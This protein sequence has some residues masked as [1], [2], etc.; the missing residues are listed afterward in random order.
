ML[1]KVLSNAKCFLLQSVSKVCQN[2]IMKTEKPSVKSITIPWDKLGRAD[3][4]TAELLLQLA[5]GLKPSQVVQAY[6]RDLPEDEKPITESYLRVIKSR[7]RE[8]F[9]LMHGDLLEHV[10]LQMVTGALY[11]AIDKAQQSILEYQ[12]VGKQGSV[13]ELINGAQMLDKLRDKLRAELD[14][15]QSNTAGA[16]GDKLKGYLEGLKSGESG[17][18]SEEPEQPMD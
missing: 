12:G 13:N 8:A 14:Q 11:T 3:N 10:R 2:A 17:A 1:N 6:N 7:Y 16:D 15:S 5:N 4:K 9:D 18:D